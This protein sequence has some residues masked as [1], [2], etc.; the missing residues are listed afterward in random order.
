MKSTILLADRPLHS[1]SF[2]EVQALSYD[3]QAL[4][5]LGISYEGCGDFRLELPVWEWTGDR[6]YVPQPIGFNETEHRATNL[7][8]E[9]PLNAQMKVSDVCDLA[10]RLR[11]VLPEPEMLPMAEQLESLNAEAEP[12]PAPEHAEA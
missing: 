3:L 9:W 12:A 8:A 1:L 11:Q 6:G 2:E 7:P 10:A 5:G 4:T